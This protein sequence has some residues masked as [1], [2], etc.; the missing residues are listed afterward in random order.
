MYALLTQFVKIG[1]SLFP[2]PVCLGQGSG[3]LHL[4][5]SL[6]NSSLGIIPEVGHITQWRWK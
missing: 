4:T 5:H 2:L 1:N 6:D 3:D